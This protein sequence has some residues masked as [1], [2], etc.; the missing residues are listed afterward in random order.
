[1]ALLAVGAAL[2]VGHL[3]DLLLPRPQLA[4][5]VPRGLLGLALAVAAGAAV[6]FLGH[7]AGGVVDGLAALIYGAVLGGVAALMGLAASYLAVEAGDDVQHSS[8]WALA[9]VQAV[10]PIAACAPVALALQWVL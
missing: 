9:V 5:D 1:V 2:V 7:Q 8:P 4:V 6:A 3:A 10:F